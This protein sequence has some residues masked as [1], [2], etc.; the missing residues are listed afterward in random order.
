MIV[1]GPRLHVPA[2][3][4]SLGISQYEKEGMSL[5]LLEARFVAQ[6]SLVRD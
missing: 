1:V 4:S 6:R 3:M 5:G 2:H